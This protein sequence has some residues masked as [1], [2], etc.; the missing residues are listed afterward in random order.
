MFST[1]FKPVLILAM[2]VTAAICWLTA[3]TANP[4][5]GGNGIV[6][7]KSSFS[8]DET[9]QRL[10]AD[11][12]KKGIKFFL[13]IDQTEL[14]TAASLSINRSTLLLFGNSALGIQFLTSNPEA[15]I[16]WP[17]RLLVIEDSNHQVWTIYNDFNWIK[18]RHGIG[19]RDQQF[20]MATDVIHS[21]TSS[22]TQRDAP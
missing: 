11:I 18:T 17:V 1:T 4:A 14:G 7:V 16:D 6:R 20:Q 13:A 9:I 2:L 21:I 22:V 15:G 8:T 19:D 12:E 5:S 10:K 3:A